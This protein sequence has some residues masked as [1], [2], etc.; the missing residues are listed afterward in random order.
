MAL[1]SHPSPSNLGEMKMSQP[2]E[3]TMESDN[4]RPGQMC[5]VV[6]PPNAAYVI[7][8]HSNGDTT[9]QMH[10]Q[11]KTDINSIQIDKDGNVKFETLTDE[12]GVDEVIAK[13]DA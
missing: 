8:V 7:I 1:E 5:V 12:F 10:D 11:C 4:V 9:I 13:A 6:R 3:I 2:S